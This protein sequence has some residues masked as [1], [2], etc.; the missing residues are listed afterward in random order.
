[1]NNDSLLKQA[2]V[3]IVFQDLN[4]DFR[5]R[6]KIATKLANWLDVDVPDFDTEEV[7][8][9]STMKRLRCKFGH[10]LVLDVLDGTTVRCR[11]CKV[12]F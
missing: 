2:V 1:M 3:I 8:M 11:R 9:G 10:D 5:A 6:R 7:P 4:L 12:V